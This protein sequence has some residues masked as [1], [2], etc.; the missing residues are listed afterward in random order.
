MKKNFTT[1]CVSKNDIAMDLFHGRKDI[2][3][4]H[5]PRIGTF[6]SAIKTPST[7]NQLNST[8]RPLHSFKINLII[9]TL[10]LSFIL[11]CF[12]EEFTLG[13]IQ[14]K[15]HTGMSQSEVVNCLGA[16]NLVTKD[17]GGC[18]SWVYDKISQSTKETYNKGWFWL[19]I[20]GRRKGCQKTETSQKTITVTL[21]FDENSSL[22][23]FTYKSSSF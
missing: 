19:L 7:N 12:S 22:E 18:E 3:L 1:G 17:I 6:F 13:T 5:S 2:R 10:F 15:I 20:T 8:R 11:P 9:L 21:N 23:S 4:C 14:K 16:P